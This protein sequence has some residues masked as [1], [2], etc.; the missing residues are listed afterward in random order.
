KG[1]AVCAVGGRTV[2][3]VLPLFRARSSVLRLLQPDGSLV[4]LALG[5]QSRS[6]F[7]PGHVTPSGTG[8]LGRAVAEGRAVAVPD[9][10]ADD[11]PTLAHDLRETLRDAG[12][13]AILAVPLRVSGT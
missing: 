7:E 5:G 13:G 9:I 4:A 8:V 10:F 3:S 11:A 2:E 1:P 6:S 12:E